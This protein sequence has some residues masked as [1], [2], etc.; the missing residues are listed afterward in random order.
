MVSAAGRSDYIDYTAY[1]KVSTRYYNDLSSTTAIAKPT[2]FNSTTASIA[3]LT[4][5]DSSF[6][7]GITSSYVPSITYIDPAPGSYQKC[8]DYFSSTMRRRLK[9]CDPYLSYGGAVVPIVPDPPIPDTAPVLDTKT[10]H[11]NY[12][13]DCP[14]DPDEPCLSGLRKD[15]G[16]YDMSMARP[17]T[18]PEL[19]PSC[20][21]IFKGTYFT[22]SFEDFCPSGSFQKSLDYFEMQLQSMQCGSSAHMTIHHDFNPNTYTTSIHVGPS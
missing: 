10:I 3:G 11:K 7:P 21:R 2:D 13:P 18:V 19:N 4:G 12:F 9:E 1:G 16:V 22:D 8:N 17:F 6:V 5:G 14:Y 20:C 15:D